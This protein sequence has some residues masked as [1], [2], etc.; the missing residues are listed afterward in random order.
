MY[1]KLCVYLL[2]LAKKLFSCP[3]HIDYTQVCM[4]ENGDSN[5]DETPPALRLQ[6]K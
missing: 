4:A 5:D 3:V 6:G 1:V 2:V